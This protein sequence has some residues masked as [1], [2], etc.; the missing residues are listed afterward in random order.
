[1]LS[2]KA[3][4]VFSLDDPHLIVYGPIVG[5]NHP[6]NSSVE[7]GSL[8]SSACG[9]PKREHPSPGYQRLYDDEHFV[10]VFSCF[11]HI[12]HADVSLTAGTHTVSGRS[13]VSGERSVQ[14]F[15][16]HC[17]FHKNCVELVED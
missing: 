9:N 14:G 2:F 1:M 10:L 16:S 6:L 12:P 4:A 11:F 7:S 17:S 15:H 3:L 5:E 8:S 13:S